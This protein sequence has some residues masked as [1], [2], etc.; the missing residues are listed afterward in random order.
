MQIKLDFPLRISILNHP[1][2]Y[3]C[4][5]DPIYGVFSFIRISGQVIILIQSNTSLGICDLS[6]IL[7]FIGLTVI[8]EYFTSFQAGYDILSHFSFLYA[9][10]SLFKWLMGG[11]NITF[12]SMLHSLIDSARSESF[13]MRHIVSKSFLLHVSYT[14]CTHIFTS[15]HF[16]SL[17]IID[18]N[19][20][21]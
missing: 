2:E 5:K 20:H 15:V 4:Q 14:I 21:V 9:N 7:F 3:S 13:E 12:F 10:S 19:F 17:V 11:T 1:H 6:N 16:S 18:V 8:S